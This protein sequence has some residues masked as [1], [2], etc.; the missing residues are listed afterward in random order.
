MD[1]EIIIKLLQDNYRIIMDEYC[2]VSNKLT[3]W[4]EK[5]IYNKG[6]DTYGLYFKGRKRVS[7]CKQCPRTDEIL[8][9]IPGL[10]TAGYSRLAPSTKIL[11]HKGYTDTVLRYHLGLLCPPECGMRVESVVYTW[12]PGKAFVFDDTLEHEAWNNSTL[13]RVVL[14]LDV[15]K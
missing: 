5:E 13:E 11:P 8:S 1:S 7:H 10:T 4:F 15:L 14:L 6:W 9:S 12:Q 3:P 2:K